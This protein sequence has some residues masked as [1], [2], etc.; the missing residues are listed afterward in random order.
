MLLDEAQIL[1]VIPRLQRKTVAKSTQ[2]MKD[3][4]VHNFYLDKEGRITK[5]PEWILRA[6]HEEDEE[7]GEGKLEKKD[8]G[9][10]L[11]CTKIEEKYERKVETNRH[12]KNEEDTVHVVLFL[13]SFDRSA[14]SLSNLKIILN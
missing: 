14:V 2:A 6:D 8:E 10:D 13:G 12:K 7:E 3:G 5:T 11:A 1:P 4:T 9:N